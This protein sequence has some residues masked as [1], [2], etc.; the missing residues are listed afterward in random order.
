[1]TVARGAAPVHDTT[2]FAGIRHCRRIIAIITPGGMIEVND[3]V[4]VVRRDSLI[5]DKSAD[6]DPVAEPTSLKKL[7]TMCRSSSVTSI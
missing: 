2:S 3:K 1:M 6:A 4:A 5:E 7:R